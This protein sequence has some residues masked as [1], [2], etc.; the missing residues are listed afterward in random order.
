MNLALLSAVLLLAPNL[1]AYGGG[2]DDHSDR[3]G[4]RHHHSHR[5]P[6][7]APA[8][9][10]PTP[11]LQ[12]LETPPPPPPTVAPGPEP[13]FQPAASTFEAPPP[14]DSKR[15][16][17]WTLSA[18][19]RRH[20][21]HPPDKDEAGKA[22]L[23][24][25]M[26]RAPKHG[27][28]LANAPL[29]ENI[30]ALKSAEAEPGSYHWH[31]EAGVRYCHYYDKWDSHWYGFYSGQDYYW[32]LY[33]DGQWWWYDPIYSRWLFW[34]GGSWWWQNPA[35]ILYAYNDLNYN[36]YGV[37]GT[38]EVPTAAPPAAVA[39]PAAAKEAPPAKPGA[40]AK[41]GDVF[42]SP[43][44]SRMI[45]IQG[46]HNE[47]FLYTRYKDEEPELL[48]FLAR[49]VSR[50]QFSAAKTEDALQIILT[51]KDGTFWL[52]DSKGRRY[53][54]PADAPAPKP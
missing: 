37:A 32:T 21:V 54:A 35:Q 2:D 44:G 9:P 43:E 15:H 22:I 29:M 18:A 16:S 30:I 25:A 20:R 8:E 17:S 46:E 19:K 49:D 50:V 53:G 10:G 31:A 7:A 6:Q 51:F 41:A 13:I 28:M 42:Y 40:D 38:T 11:P 45:K 48:T 4:G 27:A 3:E 5:A 36:P 14:Q 47:A 52:L 26:R 33:D 23:A 1:H 24:T 12:T 34:N 39:A